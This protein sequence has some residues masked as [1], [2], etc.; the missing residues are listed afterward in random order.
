MPRRQ[1][2]AIR[3]N[4][5]VRRVLLCAALLA[6][7]GLSQDAPPPREPA[8][9][10]QQEAELARLLRQFTQTYQAV[11]EN[12]ADPIPTEQAFY[13]GIIPGLLR[14]LDP[15]SAFLDPD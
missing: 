13:G 4:R 7:R 2:P 8:P 15:F 12:Y 11:E 3:Y 14:S 10:P 5:V 9:T 6:A 1:P